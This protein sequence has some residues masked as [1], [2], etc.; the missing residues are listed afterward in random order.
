MFSFQIMIK[1][2]VLRIHCEAQAVVQLA[3]HK[4]NHHHCHRMLHRSQREQAMMH[5]EGQLS[6]QISA[7][8][9]IIVKVN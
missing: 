2:L 6:L 1:E 4:V 5:M 7:I 3:Y 8:A 9:G